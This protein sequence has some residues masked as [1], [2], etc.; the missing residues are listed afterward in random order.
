MVVDGVCSPVVLAIIMFREFAV[1]GVRMIA[2]ESGWLR[3]LAVHIFASSSLTCHGLSFE[4]GGIAFFQAD[5]G[6]HN[7]GAFRFDSADNV[8][9]S[10]KNFRANGRRFRCCAGVDGLNGFHLRACDHGLN[11]TAAAPR[12]QGLRRKGYEH[13]E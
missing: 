9:R 5:N 10:H 7:S 6:P 2:A 3:G 12:P 4:H 1:A 11:G 13:G 8:L